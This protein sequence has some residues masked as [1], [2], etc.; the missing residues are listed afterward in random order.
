MELS[1]TRH[2]IRKSRRCKLGPSPGRSMRRF[3]IFA[4]ATAMLL[5]T[6]VQ[7]KDASE[8]FA[9][10][11]ARIEKTI[12]NGDYASAKRKAAKFEREM[13]DRIIA[14]PQVPEYLGEIAKLYAIAL[15]GIG[16]MDHAAWKWNTGVEF[17]SSLTDDDLADYGEVG[18]QLF[19]HLAIELEVLRE[20]HQHSGVIAPP[21]VKKTVD[22][23]YPRI[24]ASLDLSCS[25]MVQVVIETNGTPHHPVII[26][27]GGRPTLVYTSLNALRKWRFE[28]A[29]TEAGPAAAFYVLTVRFHSH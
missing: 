6:A 19:K 29:R 28:P 5:S 8:E 1:W 20:D 2:E 11:L 13:L 10:H 17:S 22:P 24:Q 14:G 25:L 27:S 4:C 15:A 18:E 16:E 7:A 26:S 12:A 9:T 21:E 3:T 23:R